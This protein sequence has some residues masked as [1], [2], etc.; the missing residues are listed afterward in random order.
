MNRIPWVHALTIVIPGAQRLNFGHLPT[1]SA[2]LHLDNFQHEMGWKYKFKKWMDVGLTYEECIQSVRSA[3]LY[4]RL[5]YGETAT[6]MD[7]PKEEVEHA[8]HQGDQEYNRRRELHAETA[9]SP[10]VSLPA[11]KCDDAF[12]RSVEHLTEYLEAVSDEN[13]QKTSRHTIDKLRYFR[14]RYAKAKLQN[15]SQG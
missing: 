6:W 2:L 3:I 5:Q 14:R 1:H 4:R 10:R 11:P 15:N 7:I 13:N 9:G 8:L 12:D